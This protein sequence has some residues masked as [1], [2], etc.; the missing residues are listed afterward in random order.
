MIHSAGQSAL[1]LALALAAAA[2]APAAAPQDP[3][4]KAKL[5]GQP[6]GLIVHPDTV[7]LT[8]PRAAQQLVVT[9]RYA[10]GSVRDLTPFCGLTLETAG[11]ASVGR[12]GFLLPHTNGTTTLI[13]EAGSHVVRVPVVV[14]ALGQP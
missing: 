5:L 14:K 9:G 10:D 1:V 3:A 11:I 6:T 7:T 12:D 8:G 4:Q 13:V 2:P